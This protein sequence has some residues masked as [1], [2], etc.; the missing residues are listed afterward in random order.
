MS[1][2]KKIIILVV[3]HLLF[4]IKNYAQDSPLNQ[5][6]N[7]ATKMNANCPIEVNPEI[8]LDHV[9]LLPGKIFQYSYTYVNLEKKNFDMEFFIKNQKPVLVKSVRNAENNS[10]FALLKKYNVTIGFYCKNK[11]GEFLTKILVKPKQYNN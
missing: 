4:F 1:S 10:N 5:I 9:I 8:R 3:V 6:L 7:K 2:N 11:Y